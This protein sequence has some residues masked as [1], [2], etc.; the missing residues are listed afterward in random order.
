MQLDTEDI[1][2]T[3][4]IYVITITLNMFLMKEF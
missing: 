3:I 1:K 2:Y 4:K